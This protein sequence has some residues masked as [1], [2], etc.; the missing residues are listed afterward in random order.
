MD[1]R[2]EIDTTDPERT[3]EIADAIEALLTLIPEQSIVTTA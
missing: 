2:V 1:I 3:R